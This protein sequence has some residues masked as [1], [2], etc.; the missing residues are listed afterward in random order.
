MLEET[1][2]DEDGP[3]KLLVQNIPEGERYG[4]IIFD[5][6]SIQTDIQ[7]D[8][9]GDIVEISGFTDYGNE[10]DSCYALKQ[11]SN[12]K[13]ISNSSLSPSF[14]NHSS[15]SHH[16]E[17]NHPDSKPASPGLSSWELDYEGD[18]NNL[19]SDDDDDVDNNDDNKTNE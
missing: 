4:G 11:G 12:E 7:I 8:K 16:S 15:T 5:E 17:S 13:K 14:T 9:H 1:L 6:M 19:H 2:K 3:K 18:G 10:G